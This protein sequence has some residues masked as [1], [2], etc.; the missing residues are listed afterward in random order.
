MLNMA[1]Q[2][3]AQKPAK[4]EPDTFV[5]SLRERADDAGEIQDLGRRAGHHQGARARQC[6][7]PDG[8]AE[9][10]DRGRAP[11]GS[12]QLGARRTGRGEESGKGEKT[13]AKAPAKVAAKAG[14]QK[15]SRSELRWKSAAERSPSTGGFRRALREHIAAEIARRGGF[16]AR[17]LTRRSDAFVVGALATTL[18]DSGFLSARLRLAQSR[19]VPV[20]GERR[21][22][23]VLFGNAD[24]TPTFPLARAIAQTGLSEDDAALMAAFDIVRV[25]NEQCAFS[26]PATFKTAAELLAGDRS[27]ADVVRI[28]ARARD[29]APEGRHKIVTGPGGEAALQWETGLTTLEGQGLLALSEETSGLED[30][31]ESAVLAEADGEF[32]EAARLYDQS[33]RADRKDAIAPYNRANIRLQQGKF[34]EAVLD[35]RRSLERD[36]DFA[37]ARYNLALALEALG[38]A[39]AAAAE[40]EQLLKT[41]DCHADA[42]FN[43]AQLTLKRG[44]L[45]DAKALYERYLHCDPPSDWAAKARK[46]IHY[47]AARMIA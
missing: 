29:L 46:A 43:L 9:A 44:A 14:R 20:F 30:L 26:D 21:F 41:D 33:A 11:S 12:A 6:R 8:R 17:D 24:T 47:C 15:E 10:L 42:L 39:E 4:F 7:E 37:E 31:F 19:T 40:L 23:G 27:I 32:E 2:I 34:D 36:P 16:V 13:A 22:S 38:K 25:E 35:Y 45:G 28:L 1:E 18:I 5:G 3:I